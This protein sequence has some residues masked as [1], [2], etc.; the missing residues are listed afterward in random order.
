MPPRKSAV[1]I[2]SGSW[3]IA[4]INIVDNNI[5][6]GHNQIEI[7]APENIPERVG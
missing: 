7:I 2:T 6:F 4:D 1:Y 3:I 5:E